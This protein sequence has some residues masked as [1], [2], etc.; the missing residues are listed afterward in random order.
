MHHRGGGVGHTTHHNA[1]KA[2][3]VLDELY[4]KVGLEPSRYSD[5]EDENMVQSDNETELQ[6]LVVN[7]DDD[8]VEHSDIDETE[9]SEI[10]DEDEDDDDDVQDDDED[11]QDDGEIE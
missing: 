8:D 11:V 6:E 9:Q 1:Q 2:N 4:S 7:A 10:D 5:D 3:F